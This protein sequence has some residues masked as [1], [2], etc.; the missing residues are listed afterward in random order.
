MM[1]WSDSL[2]TTLDELP[3]KGKGRKTPLVLA[4]LD[5]ELSQVVLKVGSN[6][7]VLICRIGDA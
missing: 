1:H 2:V 7:L 6:L 3:V 5:E 4:V